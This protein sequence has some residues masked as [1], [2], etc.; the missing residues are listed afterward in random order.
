MPPSRGAARFGRHTVSVVPLNFPSGRR[1][2][3]GSGT[4][5]SGR[6]SFVRHLSLRSPVWAV[7]Q[8][9]ERFHHICEASSND[10]RAS[11]TGRTRISRTNLACVRL[12]AF[13][14][15]CPGQSCMT[16]RSAQGLGRPSG[17]F[18]GSRAV[19][20]QLASWRCF[21]FHCGGNNSTLAPREFDDAWSSSIPPGGVSVGTSNDSAAVVVDPGVTTASSV[22]VHRAAAGSTP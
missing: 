1:C 5:I 10:L 13:C 18:G 14:G 4:H 21:G 3:A 16:T 8:D 6:L 9:Q 19:C 12:V 2:H 7:R 20:I 17:R 15:A 22:S 11:G